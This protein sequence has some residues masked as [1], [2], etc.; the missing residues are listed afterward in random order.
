MDK[1][2][3][4]RKLE[5][6]LDSNLSFKDH[7]FITVLILHTEKTLSLRRDERLV[8]HWCAS[9]HGEVG[10]VGG[11]CCRLGELHLSGRVRDDVPT[12]H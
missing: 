6:Y 9:S 1:W 2:E 7:C 4:E 8:A 10:A 3:L 5:K 12:V 11:A